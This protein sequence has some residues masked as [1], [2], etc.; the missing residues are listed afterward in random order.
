MKGSIDVDDLDLSGFATHEDVCA[1]ILARAHA[2][3]V[4][5]I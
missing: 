4:Y 2:L 5:F 3:E 1:A